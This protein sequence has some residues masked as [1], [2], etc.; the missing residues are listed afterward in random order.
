MNSACH[1]LWDNRRGR[2]VELRQRSIT[3][4]GLPERPMA[5]GEYGSADAVVAQRSDFQ[6]QGTVALHRL[7][8]CAERQ[9]AGAQV[10]SE[11]WSSRVA[12]P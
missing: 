3:A 9:A 10:W 5:I 4:F 7:G 6:A 11:S 8:Q 1:R 12:P 2:V